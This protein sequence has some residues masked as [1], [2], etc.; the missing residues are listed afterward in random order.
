MVDKEDKLELFIVVLGAQAELLR[1]LAE[2]VLD[3]DGYELVWVKVTG[4][5]NRPAAALFIDT[6]D[7][8]TRITVDEIQSAS[9]LLGDVFA[10]TFE[11]K[12]LFKQ[13]YDLEVSSPSIDRALSKLSHFKSVLGEQVLI[14]TT[15]GHD[16]PNK[17]SGVLLEV[18]RDGILLENSIADSENIFVSFKA[19]VF[20][21]MVW[22]F[23]KY[24]NKKRL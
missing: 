17:M 13:G 12:G 6:K 1:E 16:L 7:P 22:Q 3:S 2:P 15:H 21:N 9:R 24:N 23:E 18:N 11:E 20:A 14:K 5:K 8:K 4:G 19:M 10:V